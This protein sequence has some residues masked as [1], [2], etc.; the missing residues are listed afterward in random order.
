MIQGVGID[1][2]R[3]FLVHVTDAVEFLFEFHNEACI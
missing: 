3:G 2:C 1:H